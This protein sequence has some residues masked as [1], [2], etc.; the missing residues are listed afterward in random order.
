LKK[1]SGNS[2]GKGRKNT[3]W[4]IVSVALI[5]VLAAG[6]VSA[7][8]FSSS[9]STAVRNNE[10]EFGP[11]GSAHDHAAFLVII[12]G[13]RI[14]FAPSK[15]QLKSQYIHV[16]NLIGT[17]LHKHALLVP[18]GEFFKSIGMEVKND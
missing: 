17:T 12:D 14:D 9:N 15:Y 8:T 16:E 6:A 2:G 4:I 10:I 1:K 5:A 11:L 3:K 13:K 18:V 7:V